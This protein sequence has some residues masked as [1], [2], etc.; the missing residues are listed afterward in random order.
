VIKL[1]LSAVHKAH[2]KLLSRT[3]AA[4]VLELAGAGKFAVDY[5]KAH[6]TFKPRSG[7][8]Q[9]KTRWV[10][11]RGRAIKIQNTA[12]HA[13]SIESGAKPHVI[14]PRRAKM[15]AFTVKGKLVFAR[16]V[17]H[18]GNRAY[19]F[20]Y[21]ATN[22]AGRILSKGLESRMQHIASSF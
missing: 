13:H 18:P 11:F 12:G 22:A 16:K 9:A 3:S 19:R 17:N 8:L 15:L 7:E 21:R 2:E 5:V 6:P 1:D 10:P 4:V 14:R 20:L